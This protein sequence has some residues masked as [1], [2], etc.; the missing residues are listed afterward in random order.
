MKTF[1]KIAVLVIFVSAPATSFAGDND[2]QH[3]RDGGSYSNAN[4]GRSDNNDGSNDNHQSDSG[5][6]SSKGYVQHSY[7][8]VQEAYRQ[9]KNDGSSARDKAGDT[10]Q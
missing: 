4:S 1:Y 3:E 8:T 10:S 2:W 7:E 6:E 5:T 9:F